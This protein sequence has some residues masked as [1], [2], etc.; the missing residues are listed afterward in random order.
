[1]T[2]IERKKRNRQW[3]F[4]K[5][6]KNT[7]LARHWYYST[8]HEI[9]FKLYD[10]TFEFSISYIYPFNIFQQ[11]NK[12]HQFLLLNSFQQSFKKHQKNICSNNRIL[13]R[14]SKFR[15]VVKEL[16]IDQS[17]KLF[18]RSSLS[19]MSAT[20]KTRSIWIKC[21]CTRVI[22]YTRQSLNNFEVTPFPNAN[23]LQ[24]PPF[25]NHATSSRRDIQT[26]ESRLKEK[27]R[28]RDSSIFS[29]SI[30]T[31][32][33]RNSIR[34]E[35]YYWVFQRWKEKLF[36][37]FLNFRNFWIEYL[38]VYNFYFTFVVGKS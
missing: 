4:V 2:L 17:C 9:N 30:M 22:Y 12:K 25:D 21:S 10:Y 3:K 34:G 23:C 8:D 11:K 26:I 24:P 36:I 38:F 31:L 33:S 32:C 28:K 29:R 27:E 1:M 20:G 19:L 16:Q 14:N 13:I 6:V 37:Y 35:N 7:C 18:Y 5:W 15:F